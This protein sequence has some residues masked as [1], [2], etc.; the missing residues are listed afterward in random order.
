M[1]IEINKIYY[2]SGIIQSEYSYLN[3]FKNGIQ[4]IYY[5]NGHPMSE[6]YIFINGAGYQKMFKH[7]HPNGSRDFID[8][9]KNNQT[10]GFQILFNYK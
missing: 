3:G 4:K 1:E 9:N 2:I 7:W 10:H 8:Q 5:N 6:Y